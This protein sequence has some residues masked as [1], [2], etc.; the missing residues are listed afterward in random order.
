MNALSC[1]K[2]K[3]GGP[4]YEIYEFSE[5]DL[6]HID[7][8]FIGNIEKDDRSVI[9]RSVSDPLSLKISSILISNHS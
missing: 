7:D 6:N 1:P 4:D 8:N 9:A 3:L 2:S 5:S